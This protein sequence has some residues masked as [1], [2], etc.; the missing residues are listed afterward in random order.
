MKWNKGFTLVELLGVIIVIAVVALIA[1]PIALNVMNK[2]KEK[3][4]A[5]E[6]ENLVKAA[7]HYYS[8]Q[9]LE[10]SSNVIFDYQN[11]GKNSAGETL[12]LSGSRPKRGTVTITPTGEIILT[13]VGNGTYVA[14]FNSEFDDEIKITKE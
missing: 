6:M 8:K 13:N 1:S 4:F 9:Q 7:R 10:I 12:S 3:S 5:L 11:N 14:N 2:S